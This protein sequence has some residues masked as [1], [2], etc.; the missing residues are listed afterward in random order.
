LLHRLADTALFLDFESLIASF[1]GHRIATAA[2]LGEATGDSRIDVHATTVESFSGAIDQTRQRV[3]SIA[4]GHDV[5]VIGDT[6][7]DGE[8]LT[9]LLADTDAT[10]AGRMHLVV[11]DLSGGFRLAGLEV[12]VLTGAE[13][14][15]RSPIR[16]GRTRSRGK[17]IDTLA[18][19]EPGDLVIHMSHGIGLY[20]GLRH[21]EKSGQ[22]QEHLTIEFDGGTLI[23]VPASRIGLIQRY[24]GR[25]PAKTPRTRSVIWPSN[26][27]K[28][29]RPGRRRSGSR[30][31]PTTIGNTSSTRVFPTRRRTTRSMRS[32]RARMIW[33]GRG[34]WIG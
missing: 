12:L 14:F 16:R 4:A 1:R 29:K 32:K 20:R 18:Q 26:C 7:A 30:S 31:T 33:N 5:F 19:L 22:Q 11:A 24:V 6:P 9:E 34:R 8:R 25:A 27:S 28:C 13:L 21:I 2:S 15:H 17:P 10:R 3:D 23:Y